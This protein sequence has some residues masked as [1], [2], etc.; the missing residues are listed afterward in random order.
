[1][2]TDM[3]GELGTVS[4]TT[5]K[6]LVMPLGNYAKLPKSIID[7]FWTKTFGE[8]LT[9][10]T[11]GCPVTTADA[12]GLVYYYITYGQVRY[13]GQTRE[14][15]LRKRMIA[16]YSGGRLGYSYDIKRPMLQAASENKLQIRAILVPTHSLDI[17]EKQEIERYSQ[18]NKLWNQI[19]NEKNFN[20]QNFHTPVI[21]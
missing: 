7:K 16:R 14:R 11:G 21:A 2:I 18:G 1:M 12:W 5:D 20:K 8:H 15:E 3:V 19:H 10:F 13:I 6:Q 17:V 9:A 4:M